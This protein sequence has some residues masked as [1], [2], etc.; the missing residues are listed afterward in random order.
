VSTTRAPRRAGERHLWEAPSHTHPP[1]SLPCG[2]RDGMQTAAAAWPAA[3]IARSHHQPAGACLLRL[4]GRPDTHT[5]AAHA[6]RSACCRHAL[7]CLRG[8]RPG[9]A[10]S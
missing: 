1:P 10:P 4:R 7:S 2:T 6:E 3:A 9:P 8:G 5:S